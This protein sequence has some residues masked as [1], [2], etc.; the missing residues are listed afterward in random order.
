MN[1]R[2]SFRGINGRNKFII[3]EESSRDSYLLIEVGNLH[4]NSVSHSQWDEDVGKWEAEQE[5][6]R[7]F[8][9]SVCIFLSS[10]CD[11]SAAISHLLFHPCLPQR[12][13]VC[14]VHFHYIFI[15]GLC[16]M[17]MTGST[18]ACLRLQVPRL[19]VLHIYSGRPATN[20]QTTNLYHH[21]CSSAQSSLKASYLSIL[22]VQ[23]TSGF[24]CL[25]SSGAKRKP[26]LGGHYLPFPHPLS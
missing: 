13:L 21:G 1:V 6:L 11:W 18:V 15:W 10:K 26:I 14:S 19:P 22:T 5:S 3:D 16:T 20:L 17:K 12:H 25:R 23:K 4:I 9:P 7:T 24:S 2:N 8:G